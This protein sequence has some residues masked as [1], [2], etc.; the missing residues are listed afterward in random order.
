LSAQRA[1]RYYVARNAIWQGLKMLRLEPNGTVLMPAYHHG[2]E[3]AAVRAAGFEVDFY[4]VDER[5]R[6]DAEDV[7]KRISPRTRAIYLTQY[8]G[9]PQPIEEIRSAADARSLPLIEDCAMAMLGEDRGQPIGSRGD[10]AIFCLYKTLPVPDGGVLVVN[11]PDLPLPDEPVPPRSWSP[12]IQLARL[13]LDRA[14]LRRGRPGRWIRAMGYALGHRGVAA[15]GLPKAPV[16]TARFDARLVD[17]GMSRVS[18]T[19]LKH[20][21]AHAVARSRWRNFCALADALASVV[22]LPIRRLPRGACPVYFPV[23]V[24]DK[25]RFRAALAARGSKAWTFGRRDRSR[26]ASSRRS[27]DSGGKSWG[28][29]STRI[30]TSGTWTS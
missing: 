1:R 4:R 2:V 9:V 19:I 15:L 23:R 11:R 14:A 28:C 12:A 6:V 10:L 7:L 26:R 8:F 21:D 3:V 20:V 18:A 17:W 16:G 13:F 27:T 30:W 5:M 29:R 24:R 25:A 22:R